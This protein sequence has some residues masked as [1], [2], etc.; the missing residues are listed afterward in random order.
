M[1]MVLSDRAD[2]SPGGTTRSS[3][4]GVG[5]SNPQLAQ[6]RRSM[7]DLVN[8]LHSTGS[9]LKFV[10]PCFYP[11][12]HSCSSSNAVCNSTLIFPKLPSLVHRVLESLC[13]LNPYPESLC[14]VQ[15]GPVH[16]TQSSF[17]YQFLS[18]ITSTNF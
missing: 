13:S 9:V 11:T 7:L 18:Y 10:C 4:N 6:G 16:G 14:P 15:L 12:D 5:L 3:G 1:S 17:L 8:Q 2:S